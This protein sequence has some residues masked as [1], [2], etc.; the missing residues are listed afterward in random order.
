[1]IGISHLHPRIGHFYNWDSLHNYLHIR[2]LKDNETWNKNT[3]IKLKIFK[4][5][6]LLWLPYTAVTHSFLNQFCLNGF[7]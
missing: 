2:G 5:M 1:M 7:I 3:Y 4:Y 6:E